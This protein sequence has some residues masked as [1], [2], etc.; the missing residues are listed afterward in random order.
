[1]KGRS[2]IAFPFA[3][4][5]LLS[6]CSPQPEAPAP[7]PEEIHAP[8]ELTVCFDQGNCTALRG[9]WSWTVREGENQYSSTIADSL[10]PLESQDLTPTLTT[11]ETEITLSFRM[12]PDT[13]TA[14]CWPESAWGNQDAQSQE[15]AVEGN[16]LTLNPGDYLYDVHAAWNAMP[17]YEGECSYSFFVRYTPN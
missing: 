4:L 1:M 13:I 3:V 7:E 11:A 10:H 2:L 12:E 15:A 16:L 17:D 8:P 9:G 6:A 14:Q 5:C